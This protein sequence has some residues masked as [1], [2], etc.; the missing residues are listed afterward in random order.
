MSRCL[1]IDALVDLCVALDGEVES[2]LDHLAGCGACKGRLHEV[3]LARSA[4]AEELEAPP[5]LVRAVVAGF[6]APVS[7]AS[8]RWGATLMRLLNPVLAGVTS[9]VAAV[10]VLG[11]HGGPVS[12]A[13]LVGVAVFVSA[14]TLLY[15]RSP[16]LSMHPRQNRFDPPMGR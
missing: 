5:A 15:N 10:F 14:I 2:S 12:A 11:A 7:N 3:A 4:L 16:R 8:P 1:D 9:I 13:P 6:G